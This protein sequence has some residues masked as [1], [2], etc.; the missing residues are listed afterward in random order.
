MAASP[1][2][3]NVLPARPDSTYVDLKSPRLPSLQTSD[4]DLY[5]TTPPTSPVRPYPDLFLSSTEVEEILWP[6]GGIINGKG[7][8]SLNGRPPN[9]HKVDPESNEKFLSGDVVHVDKSLVTEGR[10]HLRGE[11]DRNLRMGPLSV[12]QTL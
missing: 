7:I 3:D 5:D 4:D 1:A 12:L 2:T 8:T 11:Q 6:N 9:S 10:K